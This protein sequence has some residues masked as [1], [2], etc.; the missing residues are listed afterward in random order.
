MRKL[1]IA[2]IFL[3][4]GCGVSSRELGEQF[5]PIHQQLDKISQEN[6]EQ[7][8]RISMLEQTSQ[9]ILDQVRAAQPAGKDARKPVVPV[10]VPQPTPVAT[11]PP[12]GT[13]PAPAAPVASFAEKPVSGEESR[14]KD[15]LNSYENRRYAEAETKFNDYLNAHPGGKYEPNALYWKGE[16]YFAQGH[17]A[18]AVLSFK[19]VVTRFSKHQKAADSLLKMI[20]TYKRLGDVDNTAMYLRILQEDFPD[21]GA[22]RRAVKIAGQG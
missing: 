6:A 20:I 18:E 21:S 8:R 2:V 5:L 14:Y 16:S 7:S 11:T 4:A 13:Q 15:A 17:Y 12:S 22:L 9:E 1:C 19:E 3:C 10:P